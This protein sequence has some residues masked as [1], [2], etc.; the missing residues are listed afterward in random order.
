MTHWRFIHPKEVNSVYK[1]GGKESDGSTLQDR[2]PKGKE[3]LKNIPDCVDKERAC[4][5]DHACAF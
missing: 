2:L 5:F 1:E 3:I 4:A